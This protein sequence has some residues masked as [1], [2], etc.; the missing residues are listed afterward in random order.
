MNYNV[1]SK[2]TKNTVTSYLHV[3]KKYKHTYSEELMKKN[4]S[5]AY[6]R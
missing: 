1:K 4:I 2:C 5:D 6:Q 3:A